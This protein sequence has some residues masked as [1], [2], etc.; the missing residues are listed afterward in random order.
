MGVATRAELLTAVEKTALR[1]S[2]LLRAA[3]VGYGHEPGNRALINASLTEIA[4]P[5]LSQRHICPEVRTDGP[6]IGC[7]DI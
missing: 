1:L 2:L 6:E 4:F 7:C 5:H 3:Q